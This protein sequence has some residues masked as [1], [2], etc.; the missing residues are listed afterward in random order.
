MVYCQIQSLRVY[1]VQSNK[2]AISLE[3]YLSSVKMFF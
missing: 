3:D 2:D 1:S